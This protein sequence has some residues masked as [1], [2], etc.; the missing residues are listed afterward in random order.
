MKKQKY[1]GET[2]DEERL[3]FLNK[4]WTRWRLPA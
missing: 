2:E 1:S 4:V 3:L